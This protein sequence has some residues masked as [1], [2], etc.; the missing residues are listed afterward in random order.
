MAFPHKPITNKEEP[1]LVNRPNPRMD[2]GQMPAYIKE[3]GNPKSTR[4][5]IERFASCPNNVKSTSDKT[6]PNEKIKPNIQHLESSFLRKIF[7][8]Q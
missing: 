1:I 2:K 6:T 8:N 3:L 5:Q 4:D 7:R